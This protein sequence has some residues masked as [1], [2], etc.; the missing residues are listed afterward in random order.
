MTT[1]L[2]ALSL[3]WPVITQ[4]LLC[5]SGS[6]PSD[7]ENLP[8][9]SKRCGCDVDLLGRLA[10]LEDLEDLVPAVVLILCAT[11]SRCLTTMMM[12]TTTT[13][14]RPQTPRLH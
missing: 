2:K 11:A 12:M 4:I 1:S 5:E 3:P 6:W 14:I 8:F 7:S 13:L 9:E 10:P